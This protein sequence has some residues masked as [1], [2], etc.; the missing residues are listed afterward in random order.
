MSIMPGRIVEISGEW[1]GRTP[2]L[3]SLPGTTTISTSA[4]TISRSGVTNSNWTR[5]AISGHPQNRH[6]GAARRAE[7]GTH[8][9]RPLEYRFRACRFAASRN[10]RW[11]ESASGRFRRHLAGLVDGLL[12]RADHVERG[13]GHLVILAGDDPLEPLD[14]VFEGDKDARA[15][16]EHLGDMERLRQEALD[17]ARPRDG[18]PVLFRQF[19][20]AEDRD[21][22]L[23]GFVGLQDALH[24]ARDLVVLVADHPRVEH[25]RGRVERVDRRIDPKL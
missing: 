3:P 16:G 15:A 9:H 12:D 11:E 19:V 13:F 18:Q 8:I 2:K 17:L 1:P 20:H 21:D 5:S 14:R 6:S 24:V 10:D 23:Q 4:E 25:A 22:V 7:P